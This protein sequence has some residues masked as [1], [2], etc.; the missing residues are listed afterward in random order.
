MA[1]KNIKEEPVHVIHKDIDV[2]ACLAL[3]HEVTEQFPTEPRARRRKIEP[4]PVQ[5]LPQGVS[6]EDMMALRDEQPA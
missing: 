6:A 3:R 2:E 5:Q 1:G 4:R